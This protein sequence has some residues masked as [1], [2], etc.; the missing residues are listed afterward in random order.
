MPAVGDLF[1]AQSRKTESVPA[2]SFSVGAQHV[3]PSPLHPVE[4]GQRGEA[5]GRISPA[6][7]LNDERTEL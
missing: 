4:K 6:E 1:R 3:V 7:W 5:V 2:Q